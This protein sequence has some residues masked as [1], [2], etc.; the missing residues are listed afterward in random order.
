MTSKPCSRAS[1]ISGSMSHGQPARC[2]AMTARVRGVSTART[3]SA[4]QVAGDRVDVGE[5]RARAAQ[6]DA[7]RGRHERAR[8]HDD[9]VAGAD[10]ERVQREL[11]RDAAVGER[12]RVLRA[13][14]V[15]RTRLRRTCTRCRSSSSPCRTRE[16]RAPRRSRP[17]AKCG[18]GGSGVV[19]TG[20]RRRERALAG[21]RLAPSA[22][23][24]LPALP[25]NLGIV[26]LPGCEMPCGRTS[27]SS[28]SPRMCRS[29]MNER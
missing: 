14:V 26:A 5:D 7:A 1:A 4:R 21:R 27:R 11:E 17:R 13:D 15:A 24:S 25:V 19:R 20:A 29:V 12:D 3:V 2:T 23:Y 8:G 18:H 22:G 28:V 6:H 10:A 16:P 9:V